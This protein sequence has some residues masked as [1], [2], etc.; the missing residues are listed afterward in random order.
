MLV[1]GDGMCLLCTWLFVMPKA[2]SCIRT[3]MECETQSGNEH[4]AF[5]WKMRR[6]DKSEETFREK[7][8]CSER[9]LHLN[10]NGATLVPATSIVRK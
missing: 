4:K 1:A 6:E 2:Y 5:V 9:G 3:D 10:K 8:G 7:G